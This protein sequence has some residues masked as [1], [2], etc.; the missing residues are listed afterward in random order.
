MASDHI[1]QHGRVAVDTEASYNSR[2]CSRF[3]FSRVGQILIVG[4]WIMNVICYKSLPYV[5][6]HGRAECSFTY[7]RRL[8]HNTSA[9]YNL[10]PSREEDNTFRNKRRVEVV[11]SKYIAEV[12]LDSSNECP[13]GLRPTIYT[14]D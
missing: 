8:Q 14:S 3:S 5:K 1:D 7:H 6:R 13:Y 10:K 4:A 12:T 11:L 9:V 2:A